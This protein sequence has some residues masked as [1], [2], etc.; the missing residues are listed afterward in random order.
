[1][2]SFLIYTK[3]FFSK[4]ELP[5]EAYA[6]KEIISDLRCAKNELDTAMTNFVF[7]TDPV[8]ID[9]YSYQIKAAEV[10]YN[11]HLTRA[12]HLSP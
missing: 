5:K 6:K 1:M 10:K 12:K 7:A 3:K 2:N 9:L 8:L 4:K 11:Y